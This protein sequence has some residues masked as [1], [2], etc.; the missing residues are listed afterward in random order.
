MLQAR[1]RLGTHGPGAPP[2]VGTSATPR[3]WPRAAT[4][5]AG[6][7]TA[8]R[9]PC[10]THSVHTRT[11]TL[12]HSLCTLIPV[13]AQSSGQSSL[14]SVQFPDLMGLSQMPACL[15]PRSLPPGG[16]LRAK[17]RRPWEPPGWLLPRMCSH[18]HTNHS[19]M[20]GAMPLWEPPPS[21]LDCP[22]VLPGEGDVRLEAQRGGW[23]PHESQRPCGYTSPRLR[24]G[25]Q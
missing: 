16:R 13:L 1:H 10:P 5:R 18:N 2:S 24:R 8:R 21:D 20:L 22:L 23:A 14:P 17:P 7:Q 6:T 25:Q 15:P 3:T 19:A 12:A 11:H 9:V 4:H